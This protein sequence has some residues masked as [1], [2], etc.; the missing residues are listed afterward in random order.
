MGDNRWVSAHIFYHGE[1]D[2]VLIHLVD[3]LVRELT[4]ARL[5]VA[6]FFLRYW[7]GGPHI[8]LRLLPG[9]VGPEPVRSRIDQRC[10]ELFGARPAPDLFDPADYPPWAGELARLEGVQDYLRHPY[11]NNSLAY[12]PYRREHHRYGHGAAIEAVERHFGESSQIALALIKAG[13]TTAARDT[14]ALSLLLLAWLSAAQP[15]PARPPPTDPSLEERFERQRETLRQIAQRM[16][17][18]SVQSAG[19]GQGALAAWTRSL[20]RLRAALAV[21]GTGDDDVSRVIDLCAHLACN[22]LGL[23]P[24][25]EQHLRYLA[26]R[27]I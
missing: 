23:S 16:R 22:R 8:R 11:P 27:T 21:A 14:A 15:P 10:A 1:L 12:F 2:Q 20:G 18:I 24:A 7:D 5:A 25:D 4:R 6:S 3:P 9:P 26:T 13:L 19:S 17:T